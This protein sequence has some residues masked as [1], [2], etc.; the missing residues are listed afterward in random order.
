MTNITETPSWEPAVYQIGISD[1]IRG[2]T[3]LFAAGVP[4]DGFD[5]VQALQLANRTSYLKQQIDALAIQAISFPDYTEIRDYSGPV[6]LCYVHGFGI[7]GNFKIDITDTTSLDNDGTCIIDALGRRWKRLYYGPVDVKWFGAIGDNTADDTSAFQSAVNASNTVYISEGNYKLTS[8]ITCTQATSLIGETPEQSRLYFYDCNGVDYQTASIDNNSEIRLEH[9]TFAAVSKGTRKAINIEL[10]SGATTVNSV[11]IRDCA[12]IGADLFDDVPSHIWPGESQAFIQEWQIGADVYEADGT[13]ITDCMFR[14]KATAI[15]S[16]FN[17]NTIGIRISDTNGILIENNKFF[18][19]KDGTIFTGQTEGS[20]T[21]RNEIVACYRGSTVENTTSPSN[22]HTFSENH[23]ACRFRGI[24]IDVN[25]SGSP[26]R[27]GQHFIHSNFFLK[28]DSSGESGYPGG[29][30]GYHAIH[31][32]ITD[33]HIYDNH[34][35]SNSTADYLSLADMGVYANG[36]RIYVTSN[37]GYNS[38]TMVNI[39]VNGNV[40]QV[41]G[42][43][44]IAT[45]SSTSRV[46]SDNG[47]TT[48]IYGNTDEENATRGT[49]ALENNI[50]LGFSKAAGTRLIDIHS[51]G[52]QTVSYDTRLEFLGGTSTTGQGE[53]RVRTATFNSL[54]ALNVFGGLTRPDGDNTRQLGASGN[55]WT[56]TYS[57]NIRPGDGTATWTSGVGSPEGV[58]TA[59]VGSLYTRTDGSTGTTLY[60]KETGTGSTGWV[61]K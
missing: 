48:I 13:V 55:R 32:E 21:E 31:A 51:G 18:L 15:T 20:R 19:I 6:G 24:T 29:E 54:A 42:N 58:V 34:I 22:H 8:V 37:T 38:G 61:A 10:T 30:A 26:T 28:R 44:V 59:V 46:V 25:T 12:F 52:D 35:Q 11:Y 27:S 40:C 9:V 36:E 17:T 41:I 16:S 56:N 5:N 45:G 4:V 53:M 47:L 3:P 60:I 43:T 39:G 14:G 57:V 7:A 23:Y 50:K 33:S 2:G 1:P 49:F